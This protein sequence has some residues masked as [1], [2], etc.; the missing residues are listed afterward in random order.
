MRVSCSTFDAEA[1]CGLEQR[2]QNNMWRNITF[3]T[4][5]SI[6]PGCSVDVRL[7]TFGDFF[8][9]LLLL[10]Q[11]PGINYKQHT[12]VYFKERYLEIQ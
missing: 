8:L 6:L 9:Q 5:D 12:D 7:R 10:Q 3:I 11:P 4:D 1:H 2:Q